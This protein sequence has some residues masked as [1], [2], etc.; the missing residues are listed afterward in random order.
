MRELLIATRNP[1]KVAEIKAALQGLPLTF[2]SLE[3][4][5]AG[6]VEET[7]ATLVENAV[8]KAR[9]YGDWTGKLAI[10]DDSGLE[11]DALNGAPGV[12]SAR[13]AKSDSARI[14]KLLRELASVPEA[15]RTA[16]FRSVIAIHDPAIG[17][18]AVAEGSAEG[19]I[20]SARRGEQGFGYDPIFLYDEARKSGGE[21]SREEKNAVS[22]RGKALAKARELLKQ[23]I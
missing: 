17:K 12:A 22:H 20:L 3:D 6:D 16:K 2:V 19:H 1:G 9:V 21:M 13:Y 8:L 7:G 23:Y 15:R 14:D 10:A 4:T 5:D 18:T 11:V